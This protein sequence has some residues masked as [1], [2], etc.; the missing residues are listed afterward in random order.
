MPRVQPAAPFTETIMDMTPASSTA[1]APEAA[2]SDPNHHLSDAVLFQLACQSFEIRRHDSV[3][4]WAMGTV[5][6][7]ALNAEP[8]PAWSVRA[9]QHPDRS[10]TNL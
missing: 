5:S 1:G 9:P 3:R 10:L 2:P 4:S 7:D 6:W 8:V